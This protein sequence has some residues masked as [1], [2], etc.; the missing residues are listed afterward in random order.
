VL[1]VVAA[2]LANAVNIFNFA[3][4]LKGLK[5]KSYQIHPFTWFVYFLKNCIAILLLN[6]TKNYLL[7]SVSY[8]QALLILII[9]IWGSINLYSRNN[10]QKVWNITIFDYICIAFYLASFITYIVTF[11]PVIAAIIAFA[12]NCFGD[13]PTIR[14]LYVAPQTDKGVYFLLSSA[15]FFVQTLAIT[16]KGWVGYLNSWCWGLWIL[17]VEFGVFMYSKYLRNKF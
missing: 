10:A 4:R 9:L 12:G 11:N 7:A 5:N 6:A 14:K 2:I 13:L 8:L 15:K 3:L 1:T 16:Q 17:I